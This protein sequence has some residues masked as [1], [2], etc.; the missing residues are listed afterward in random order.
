MKKKYVS[1]VALLMFF[2]FTA[3]TVGAFVPPGLEKKGG[4]PPGIQKRFL[5]EEQVKEEK[6]DK[7]LH[8]QY[9]TTI[10]S[11]DVQTRRI[12]IKEGTAYIYLLIADSVKVE[13]DEKTGSLQ[14]LQKND[15]VV[16]K[17]DKNNTVVEI[18]AENLGNRVI[19]MKE[20]VIKSISDKNREIVVVHNN[21]EVLYYVKDEA[22]IEIDGERKLLEDIKVN[23]KADIKVRGT[24]VI[25]IKVNQGATKYEGRLIAKYTDDHPILV[26]RIDGNDK[27]FS[28]VKS[29]DL[30]EV[31]V[32]DNVII[33]VE[34]DIVT[35]I[36]KK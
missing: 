26:L 21:K 8:N 2:T 32:G 1:L 4:L 12:A 33:R 7:V 25:E 27:I 9:H 35:S 34:K 10:E 16:L 36:A 5:Q 17:L 28:V 14:E 11:I 22:I 6:S 15:E 24:D 19:T 29:L 3:S 30:R 13:I 18:Y 23:M 20:V 31:K